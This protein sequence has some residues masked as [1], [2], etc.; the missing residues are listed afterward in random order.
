MKSN[1]YG[2]ILICLVVLLTLSV[3][4]NLIFFQR[5]NKLD[6]IVLHT[7][8]PVSQNDLTELSKE[9]DR[10]SNIQYDIKT[11]Q[12]IHNDLVNPKR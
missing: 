12:P 6:N 1:I 3:S 4:I 8:A 11:K 5:I 10:L 7:T 9:I 2:P